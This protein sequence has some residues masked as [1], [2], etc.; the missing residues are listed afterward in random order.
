LRIFF[1]LLIDPGLLPGEVGSHGRSATGHD[2][3]S[4][5]IP[6]IPYPFPCFPY[7][8]NTNH[9]V[10]RNDFLISHWTI[11]SSLGDTPDW[12]GDYGEIFYI[13]GQ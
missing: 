13:F 9:Y 12:V 10:K 6:E 3:V 5:F 7:L 4:P 11:S 8:R 2:P 1:L